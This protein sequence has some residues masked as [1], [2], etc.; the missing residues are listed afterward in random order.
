MPLEPA[1]TTSKFQSRLAEWEWEAG[2]KNGGGVWAEELVSLQAA[3]PPTTPLP[4]PPTP[5]SSSLRSF[6]HQGYYSPERR[7]ESCAHIGQ[8]ARALTS[9]F[10]RRQQSERARKRRWGIKQW[11]VI[12]IKMYGVIKSCCCLLLFW[13]CLGN[14]APCLCSLDWLTQLWPAVIVSHIIKLWL[15]A[16]YL[17]IR[18]YVRVYS[19]SL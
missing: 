12:E 19:M 14:F 5:S 1:P 17:L 8:A 6:Q 11:H 18:N 3:L 7:A 2:G 9:A 15:I 4:Q 16:H 13:D 10:S